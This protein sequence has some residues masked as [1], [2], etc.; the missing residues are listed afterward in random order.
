MKGNRIIPTFALLVIL[1]CSAGCGTAQA[2]N[3]PDT[4]ETAAPATTEEPTTEP[5]ATPEIDPEVLILGEGITLLLRGVPENASLDVRLDP[6][7]RDRIPDSRYYDTLFSDLVNADV[8][9]DGEKGALETGLAE[10]CFTTEM[11]TMNEK[12]VPF[13]WDTAS[14]PLVDGRPQ[15]V[16]SSQS[17]SD[18]VICTMITVSG[19]YGLIQR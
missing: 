19:L 2:D 13:Y 4:A 5:T 6:E 8:L 10:L 12:P 16:S 14:D 1:I 3:T 9:V 7:I 17:K 18:L 15:R 11:T